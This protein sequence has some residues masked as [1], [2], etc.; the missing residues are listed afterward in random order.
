MIRKLMGLALASTALA[1]AAQAAD[2]VAGAGAKI[3]A[4]LQIENTTDLYFGTIAPSL[5]DND[6]VQV[7]FDGSKDCGAALSCL[8][9][10]HTAA[11]FAVSGAEGQSYTIALP[12]QA[13][14]RNGNGDEMTIANFAGSKPNGTLANGTDSFTVGGVLNVAARQAAGDYQGTFVVTVEYQ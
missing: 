2:V 7:S 10:D 9:D 8:S 14:I 3:V 13:T 1:S 4:P 6:V 5:T 11:A 12:T